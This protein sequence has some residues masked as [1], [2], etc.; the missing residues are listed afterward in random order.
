MIYP[1][2][3]SLSALYKS[4]VVPELSFVDPFWSW[5]FS[6]V[7]SVILTKRPLKY[8]SMGPESS[9]WFYKFISREP[10]YLTISYKVLFT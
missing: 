8:N 7:F 6:M 2:F 1:V 9:G 5:L 4:V 10:G 3:R